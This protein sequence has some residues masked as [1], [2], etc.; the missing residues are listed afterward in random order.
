M[1]ATS[2]TSP[3]LAAD[4]R[5]AAMRKTISASGAV[6]TKAAIQLFLHLI[7]LKSRPQMVVR[8]K[9]NINHEP[10]YLLYASIKSIERSLSW[11]SGSR[12]EPQAPG[13]GAGDRGVRM[14]TLAKLLAEKQQLIERLEKNSGPQE[15]EEIERLLAKIN[16]AQNLLDEAGPADRHPARGWGSVFDNHA[17]LGTSWL[18]KLN[19]CSTE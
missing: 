13:D 1:A 19:V 2:P 5:N 11:S 9:G 10:H 17:F 8:S 4:H 7:W 15:R 14:T 3:A 18:G 6:A 16:A 12:S